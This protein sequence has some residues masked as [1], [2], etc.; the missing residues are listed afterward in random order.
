MKCDFLEKVQYLRRLVFY[1]NNTIIIF[2]KFRVIGWANSKITCA[3][4]DK[5]VVWEKALFRCSPGFSQK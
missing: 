2:S 4:I 5:V 1:S 3:N